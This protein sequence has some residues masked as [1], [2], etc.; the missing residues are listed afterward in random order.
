MELKAI[1]IDDEKAAR[2]VLSTL[3]GLAHPTVDVIDT[4]SNLPEAVISIRKHQPDVVFLDVEMPQFSGYEIIKFFDRIEFQIVFVTAYDKYAVKAFEMNAADYLVK[5]IQ[6]TRLKEAVNRV[7]LRC[8]EQI[9]LVD[10]RSVLER[11]EQNNS[12]V[13][14][15]SESGQKLLLKTTQI[16]AIQAQGSYCEILLD[17]GEKHLVSKNIGWIE[18]ELSQNQNLFRSHKSWIINLRYIIAIQSSKEQLVLEGGIQ[19]KLSRFKKEAFQEAVEVLN[20]SIT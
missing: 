13:L 11:L 16:V 2:N 14:T 7:E 12:P 19:A 1:I 18:K 4:C 20:A 15:I 10:Y 3:L 8:K 5:P 17:S 9:Q 6:R